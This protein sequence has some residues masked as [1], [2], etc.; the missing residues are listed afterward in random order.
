MKTEAEKIQEYLNTLYAQLPKDERLSKLVSLI[1]D[2]EI[3]LEKE[4]NT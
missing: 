4:C 3:E 2:N 1:V